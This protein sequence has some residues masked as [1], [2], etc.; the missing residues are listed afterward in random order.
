M[1]DLTTLM[2]QQWSNSPFRPIPKTLILQQETAD[3]PQFMLTV[4]DESHIPRFM[5]VKGELFMALRTDCNQAQDRYVC[6]KISMVL[7]GPSNDRDRFVEANLL[8]ILR[9]ALGM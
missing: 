5:N 8:P 1:T 3:G 7:C 2:Q 4:E 6:N 9:S